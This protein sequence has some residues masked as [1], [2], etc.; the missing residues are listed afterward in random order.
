MGMAYGSL[1]RRYRESNF[2]VQTKFVDDLLYACHCRSVEGHCVCL[3][4]RRN[5]RKVPF[6]LPMAHNARVRVNFSWPAIWESLT[7]LAGD[8]RFPATT[9]FTE[10]VMLR[11][12]KEGRAE[13][14]ADFPWRYFFEV[15]ARGCLSRTKKVWLGDDQSRFRCE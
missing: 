15:C 6:C 3:S 10:Q 14:E 12:W 8:M 5:Y 1:H 2:S 4:L 13:Y 9:F 7:V 11:F